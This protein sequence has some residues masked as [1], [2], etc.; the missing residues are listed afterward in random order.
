MTT[1][2]SRLRKPPRLCLRAVEFRA[3]DE[4]SDGRTLEGYAAT[5]GSP[6]LIDS[7]E[8]IFE[9]EIARGAFRRSLGERT[10]V[11]QFDHGR[12]MRTGSVPIGAIEDLREDSQGLF[13]RARMFDNPVVEP[14]RQAIEGGAIAGMSFRFKV[15]KDRWRD[16]KGKNIKPEE[17]SALLWSADIGDRGPLKR[18]ITEVELF[19]LGPVVFPAYESTSVG[20]RSILSDLGEDERRALISELAAEIRGDSTDESDAAPE[21][22]SDGIPDDAAPEGTR[23]AVNPRELLARIN[24]RRGVQ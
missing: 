4:P 12:D 24:S 1:T 8:G 9:E 22:T 10:P 15:T 13:V 6:T 2:M 21:G 17:L 23:R 14:I 11:L 3:S 18:T 16:A 19:E 20:V 5:F 7:W